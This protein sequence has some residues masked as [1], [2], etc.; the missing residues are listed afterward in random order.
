MNDSIL[1]IA[2]VCCRQAIKDKIKSFQFDT[3]GK[4]YCNIFK[5]ILVNNR[6]WLIKKKLSYIILKIIKFFFNFI[7][8]LILI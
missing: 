6:V 3:M 1:L 8:L 5:W 7:K 2:R 4:N